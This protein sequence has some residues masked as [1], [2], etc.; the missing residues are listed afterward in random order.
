MCEIL[1]LTSCSYI[2]HQ[3]SVPLSVVPRGVGTPKC[4]YHEA[5]V[6]RNIVPRGVGIPKSI[7]NQLS[8]ESAK[9]EQ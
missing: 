7:Y 5:S 3:V 4:R 2:V 6:P 9:T 8:L 1:W